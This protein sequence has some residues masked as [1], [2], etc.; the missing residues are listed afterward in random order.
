MRKPAPSD[1]NWPGAG[2]RGRAFIKMHGLR[3]HFVIVD[4]RDTPYQPDEQEIVAI[5]D[6]QVGVGG[7]QLVVIEAPPATSGDK[8]VAAF[9][10]FYNVDG[11]EAEACGNA[12]RC[13]PA[14]EL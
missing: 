5:C 7:D 2:A 3:N 4:G 8:G 1:S 9:V 12:T 6:S 11:P 10:R 14:R 13:V